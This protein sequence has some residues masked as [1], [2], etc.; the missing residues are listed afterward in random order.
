VFLLE[1][2]LYLKKWQPQIRALAKELILWCAVGAQTCST[3]IGTSFK[4]ETWSKTGKKAE[5][6]LGVLLP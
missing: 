5:K 2:V 6:K 1:P 3:D 4:L